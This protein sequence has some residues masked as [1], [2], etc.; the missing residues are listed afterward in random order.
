MIC[1]TI[2][3]LIKRQQLVLQ[4]DLHN[5]KGIFTILITKLPFKQ[6]ATAIINIFVD[7]HAIFPTVIIFSI[8]QGGNFVNSIKKTA[9]FTFFLES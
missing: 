1:E 9:M 8:F 7:C 3:L 6:H 5:K 2:F 4:T